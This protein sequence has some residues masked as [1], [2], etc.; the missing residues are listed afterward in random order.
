VLFYFVSLLLHHRL[1][2]LRIPNNPF[3]TGPL[4]VEYGNTVCSVQKEKKT[5]GFEEWAEAVKLIRQTVCPNAYA[6]LLT[7]LDATYTLKP[8][9]WIEALV[10]AIVPEHL[11]RTSEAAFD[12]HADIELLASSPVQ[13]GEVRKIVDKLMHMMTRYNSSFGNVETAPILNPAAIV[14]RFRSQGLG[15][16]QSADSLRALAMTSSNTPELTKK[17]SMLDVQRH[18]LQYAEADDSVQASSEG[19]GGALAAAAKESNKQVTHGCS[20]CGSKRHKLYSC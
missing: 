8:R 2:R 11:Q 13:H 20:A 18:L 6:S 5:G 12:A 16:A 3:V 15:N 10:T 14:E 17:S 4:D 1:F 7:T 19:P 9:L